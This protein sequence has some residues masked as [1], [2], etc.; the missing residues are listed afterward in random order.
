MGGIIPNSASDLDTYREGGGKA[1]FRVTPNNNLT[2][3]RQVIN[4]KEHAE[5]QIVLIGRYNEGTQ[6]WMPQDATSVVQTRASAIAESGDVGEDAPPEPKH[7]KTPKS[8][9]DD[10][11]DDNE[12]R[13][14]S[15]TEE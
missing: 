5:E 11:D 15:G 4:A 2:Y 8:K 13:D 9:P 3:L 12:E 7:K 6:N 14:A 10:G 1:V